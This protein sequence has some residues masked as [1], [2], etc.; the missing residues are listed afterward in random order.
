VSKRR[1]MFFKAAHRDK[2][3]RPIIQALR[4]VGAS[5]YAVSGKDIP[6]LLVGFGGVTYLFEVKSRILSEEKGRKARV[7]ETAISPGQKEFAETWKGG[8]ARFIYEPAEA[9]RAIGAPYHQTPQVGLRW[10]AFSGAYLCDSCWVPEDQIHDPKCPRR[11][12]LKPKPAYQ[13][14]AKAE[15]ERKAWAEEVV[16]KRI[17]PAV[18]GDYVGDTPKS[19]LP[20]K[21][22]VTTEQVK[23][24][25][26][27]MRPSRGVEGELQPLSRRES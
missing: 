27:E 23:A 10:L 18:V 11:T 24:A 5:V 1:R 15:R 12:R 19:T 16:P 7:R 13:T 22:P 3:E 14:A 17:A 2:A 4:S 6:D 8:P 20:T 21:R 25:L 26:E 9:L